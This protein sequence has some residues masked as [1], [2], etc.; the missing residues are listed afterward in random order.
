[1]PAQIYI[2]QHKDT[3]IQNT[4]KKRGLKK[5]DVLEIRKIN[6]DYKINNY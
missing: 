2:L 3:N 6:E 1:M 5:E 4:S